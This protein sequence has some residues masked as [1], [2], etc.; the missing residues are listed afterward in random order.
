MN[1]FK[2]VLS[3]IVILSYSAISQADS[4][5]ISFA[6]GKTQTIPL[7]GSVKSIT[8]VQYLS[9]SD[10]TPILPQAKNIILPQPQEAKQP[11]QPQIPAKQNVR[12]KW[13]DPITGQ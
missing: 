1:I 7:D 9:S 11:S 5:V 13:A 4:V 3:A 8:A 12:F 2:I 10:Q 6:D